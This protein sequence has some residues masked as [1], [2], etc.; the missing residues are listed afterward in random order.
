MNILPKIPVSSLS[1]EEEKVLI[2]K[3][4]EMPFS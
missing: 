4:T 2:H 3:G 1:P